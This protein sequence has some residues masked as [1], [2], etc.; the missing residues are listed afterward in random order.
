MG[1][2]KV[3]LE[4]VEKAKEEAAAIIDGANS[5]A[6]AI[7]KAAEKQMQDYEKSM[8]ADLE[9]DAE[10]L[11]M[12][13]LTSAELE[14]QRQVLTVKNELIDS[15]FSEAAKRLGRL[16]EREREAHVKKLLEAALKELDAPVIRCSPKDAKFV[17]G[18]RL[19]VIEDSSIT[20]G[21]IAESLDGRLR[22]DYSYSALIEQVKARVLSNV[23]RTLFG[24]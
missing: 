20:G 3:K 23:A 6:K 10:L 9:K 21:I 19:K 16:P 13:D 12:K 2:E 8:E 1:L 17:Q 22:V 5:E 18:R 24:K 11:R 4:I 15:V 7:M 14:A